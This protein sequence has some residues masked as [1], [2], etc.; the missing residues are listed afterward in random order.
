L[1]R[2]C[3][4]EALNQALTKTCR[5][6]EN[7]L[8]LALFEILKAIKKILIKNVSSYGGYNRL[9]PIPAFRVIK[10]FVSQK[11]ICFTV[12]RLRKIWDFVT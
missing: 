4:S 8:D 3:I 5:N 10:I 2:C 9:K 12:T 7:Y 6:F 1:G 11:Q